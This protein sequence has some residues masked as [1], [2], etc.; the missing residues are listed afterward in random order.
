MKEPIQATNAY[1]NQQ[2]HQHNDARWNQ[3]LKDKNM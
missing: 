1:V 2:G 3:S